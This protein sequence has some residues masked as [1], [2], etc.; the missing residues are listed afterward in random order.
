MFIELL[1]ET[2][3]IIK[4][5]FEL[6]SALH[7]N[8]YFQCAKILQYPKYTKLLAQEIINKFDKSETNI[9]SIDTVVS[10]A[11]GGLLIGYEVAGLLGKRHIFTEKYNN[12]LVLRR[13][14]EINEGEKIIIIEDVITTAS[15]SIKTQKIVEK[16]LGEVVGI[17]CII[18]RTDNQTEYSN[19]IKSVLQLEVPMYT[20]WSCPECL[21]R[22]PITKPSSKINI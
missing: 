19:T 11:L 21:N 16:R 14:F 5:H 7:S 15:S 12:T 17:G 20:R 22:V 9:N 10:P 2:G 18:D 8:T 4:G 3:A 13:G 1:E 6:S